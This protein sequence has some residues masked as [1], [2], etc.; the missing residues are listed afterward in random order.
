MRNLLNFVAIFLYLFQEM[1]EF[2]F[3]YYRYAHSSIKISENSILCI[4]G[5]GVSDRDHHGRLDDVL[6][7]NVEHD[8]CTIKRIKVSGYGPGKFVLLIRVIAGFR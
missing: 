8:V 6:L 4:G 2:Y 1:I 7:I 3:Y 5:F